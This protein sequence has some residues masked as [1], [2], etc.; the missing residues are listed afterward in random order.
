MSSLLIA[1]ATLV[2]TMDDHDAEIAGG[3]VYIEDR[4]I[5]Q[6]GPMDSLPGTAEEVIDARG[7]VILPGLVNTHH[8]FFQNLTRAVPI[9]Q[10]SN[11]FA[12]LTKLY[13]IW[14]RLTPE[15]VSI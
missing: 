2:A 15:A 1:N 8:H 6:V 3:G 13:P 11:L 5:R 7:M 4:E 9:A 14:G 10:E 12:W